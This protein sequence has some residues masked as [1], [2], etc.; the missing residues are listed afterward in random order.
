MRLPCICKRD[1]VLETCILTDKEDKTSLDK[2]L[3]STWKCTS[4][5]TIDS[6]PSSNSS[7]NTHKQQEQFEE[8]LEKIETRLEGLVTTSPRNHGV[9]ERGLQ[10]EPFFSDCHV[11]DVDT[12]LH[13]QYS[14]DGGISDGGWS[15]SGASVQADY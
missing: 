4:H 13:P 9:V 10:L 15:V 7:L 11:Y 3:Y 14:D 8:V 1:Y 5:H 6:S 2:S 12:P